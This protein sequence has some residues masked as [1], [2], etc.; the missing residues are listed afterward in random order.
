MIQQVVGLL[1]QD[2][3]DE[4]LHQF[5]QPLRNGYIGPRFAHGVD[6]YVSMVLL[7]G[8]DTTL[9]TSSE[10]ETILLSISEGCFLL[11][12]NKSLV[13]KNFRRKKR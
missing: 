9:S 7:Q 4:I 10:S 11:C 12:F 6:V 8:G 2:G 1:T 3:D 5:R 13:K